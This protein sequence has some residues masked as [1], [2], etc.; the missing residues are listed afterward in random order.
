MGT[1]EEA[2]K[3]ELEM[4]LFMKPAPDVP[5]EPP[6]GFFFIRVYPRHPWL[7]IPF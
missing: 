4:W 6:F 3:R 5:P 2:K 1:D 7:K